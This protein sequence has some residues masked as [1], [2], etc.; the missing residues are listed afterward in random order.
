MLSNS[1]NKTQGE[2]ISHRLMSKVKP[3]EPIKNKIDFAQKQLQLQ[4]SKL[5]GIN[6]KLTAK[7]DE[8]FNKIVDAQRNNK[9]VYAQ[10]YAGELTQV[11]KMKNMVS[12]AKL[13]MEQV[14]LRLDTVSELG[15]IVVTLSPCMS[16]I[17]G[18][19]PSL[20]GLMPEA[21]LAMQDLSMIL[22]DVMSGSSVG[23]NN[24]FTTNTETNSDTLA[25]L[26]EAHGI[27]AGQTESAI[28]DIPSELRQHVSQR[29]TDIFI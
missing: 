20:T 1:W 16:I 13:S 27:I 22:G 15:D 17:K 5:S 28:P 2:S 26:E 14:K 23:M 9:P 25:I 29:R 18:L 4:I 6:E 19:S 3:D 7:H 8:L 11:R 12:G 21:G 10:A 24:T